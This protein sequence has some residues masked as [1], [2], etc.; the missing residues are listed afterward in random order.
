MNS[1]VEGSS[2]P[3]VET[4]SVSKTLTL[5]Q[6]YPFVCHFSMICFYLIAMAHC[7]SLM[8]IVSHDINFCH[9]TTISGKIGATTAGCAE[10]EQTASI[11][12]DIITSSNENIFRVTGPL[13]EQ[14]T[15]HRWIP[16]TKASNAELWCFLWSA[17]E[18]TMEWTVETPVNWDATALIMT[19]IKWTR[20]S[21]LCTA[22]ARIVV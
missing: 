6:Q 19:S 14:F 17:P 5:S 4:F 10:L 16:L 15:G 3:Q 20:G 11:T 7:G 13:S 22:L 9:I 8:F 18:Q 12:R 1:K 21:S 2:P